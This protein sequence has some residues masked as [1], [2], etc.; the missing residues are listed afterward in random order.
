VFAVGG[1]NKLS[2]APGLDTMALHE[3]SDAYSGDRDR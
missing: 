1:H 2:L 3:L